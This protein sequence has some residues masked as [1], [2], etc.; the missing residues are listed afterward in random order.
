MEQKEYL[1]SPRKNLPFFVAPYQTIL[2]KDAQNIFID[3]TYTSNS[4]FRYLLNIVAFNE[5]MLDFNAVSRVLCGKQ[6]SAADAPAISEI[7]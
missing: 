3:I 6:D 5:S 7:F 2:L 1:L 4:V